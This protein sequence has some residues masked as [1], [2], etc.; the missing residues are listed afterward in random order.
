MISLITEHL[1]VQPNDNVRVLTDDSYLYDL[2]K[3]V[4]AKM[5]S[6]AGVKGRFMW[7]YVD[8]HVT[9]MTLPQPARVAIPPNATVEHFFLTPDAAFATVVRVEFQRLR[10]SQTRGRG[11]HLVG[12]VDDE[13]DEEGES[14]EFDEDEGEE[15][16]VPRDGGV[17][18]GQVGSSHSH[19][20]PPFTSYEE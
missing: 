3:M 4:S 14:D 17:G 12:N 13:N 16:P 7:I 20:P 10:C 18:S 8:R 2:S 15:E 5:I 11:G 6:F 9:F 19:V 1:G